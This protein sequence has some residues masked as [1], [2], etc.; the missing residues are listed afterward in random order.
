MPAVN[1]VIG[2]IRQYTAVWASHQRRQQVPRAPKD[3][4]LL[5]PWLRASRFY[6]NMPAVYQTEP[7]ADPLR[8]PVFRNSL[9]HSR[10]GRPLQWQNRPDKIC[11]LAAGCLAGLYA[12]GS[13]SSTFSIHQVVKER[14][15]IAEMA[16][17]E[18]P[19]W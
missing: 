8:K 16:V 2:G 7:F 6:Y 5:K 10:F 3:Q 14:T 1:F 12:N 11:H 13:A 19:G 9:C 18:L 15:P 17:G 4:Q